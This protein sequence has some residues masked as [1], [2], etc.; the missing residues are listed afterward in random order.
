MYLSVITPFCQSF[1][2]T[3]DSIYQFPLKGKRDYDT[4]Y[5]IVQGAGFVK[6][7]DVIRGRGEWA[8]DS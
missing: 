2:P 6:R 8:I 4:V 1:Y 3:S 5:R 7:G